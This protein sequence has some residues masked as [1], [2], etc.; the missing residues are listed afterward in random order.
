MMQEAELFLRFTYQFPSLG[1][2]GAWI[3]IMIHSAKSTISKSV[4][5]NCHRHAHLFFLVVNLVG[6]VT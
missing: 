1:L 6:K 2:F 4:G 3:H 5:K